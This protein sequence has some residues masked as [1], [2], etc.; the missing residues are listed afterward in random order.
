MRKNAHNTHGKRAAAKLLIRMG[1]GD[2]LLSRFIDPL[3]DILDGTVYVFAI[4]GVFGVSIS[5]STLIAIIALKKAVEY[6]IGYVDEH[7]GF[8]KF[9]NEYTSRE[10][11]PFNK[12]LL[13]RIVNIERMCE[14]HDKKA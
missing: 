1:R 6:I 9:E 7:V 13:N 3:R 4:K 2:G 12:E 11:N 14:N 8:W 10:I 5:I